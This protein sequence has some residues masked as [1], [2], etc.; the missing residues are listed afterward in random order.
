MGTVSELRINHQ[1][2]SSIEALETKRS[3]RP[4]KLFRNYEEEELVID[5]I[6]EL[7]QSVEAKMAPDF[8]SSEEVDVRMQEHSRRHPAR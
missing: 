5:W 2:Q 1:A 7:G 3:G 6:W 4:W 8:C